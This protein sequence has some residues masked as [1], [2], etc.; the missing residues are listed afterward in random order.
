MEF[1][2]PPEYEG[3]ILREY[4]RSFPFIS[5]GIL[6]ELKK[7]GGIK[8]NG[9]TVT[10]RRVLRQGDVLDIEYKD[11]G[12][13]DIEPVDLPLD[14]IYEDGNMTAVNKP[15]GMPTHPSHGHY[16]DTL[17]NALAYHYK[18]GNFVFRAV[19]RLDRETSGVVLTAKSRLAAYALSDTMKRG[20][21][22]KVYYALCEGIFDPPSGLITENIKRETE[23][24]IL[25]TVCRASEGRT[26]VTE[27]ETLKTF[28]YR[29]RVLS[30]V[31]LIPKTGRTHQLRVHTAFMRAPICGDG[32]YGTGSDV[33]GFLC[34]HAAELSFND[35]FSGNN[36]TLV[37]GLP[38]NFERILKEND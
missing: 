22:H 27:Y 14:I 30:Y 24:I 18:D 28:E 36:I 35:P 20:G 11:A 29:G 33:T 25:R 5:G 3:K 13:S 32:L 10:V 15:S 2:I 38:E 31:R 4:L 12:G 34:L 16:G 37:A 7:T 26:A 19:N 1:I 8:V 9:Q 6:T 23:S 17:A 21:F